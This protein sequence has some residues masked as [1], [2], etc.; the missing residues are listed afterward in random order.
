[1]GSLNQSKSTKKPKETQNL[2]FSPDFPVKGE[3]KKTE[4]NM[5]T[6]SMVKNL[7]E[8]FVEI[9][10]Y[11]DSARFGESPVGCD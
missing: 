8:L 1:M 3:E 7:L 9:R 10:W 4:K 5:K 2:Q 11:D 6:R